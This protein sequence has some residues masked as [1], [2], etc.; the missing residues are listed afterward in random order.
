MTIS[1]MGVTQAEREQIADCKAGLRRHLEK[2][3]NRHGPPITTA[4]LAE[5]TAELSYV[6]AGRGLT[7]V[8]F[9]ELSKQIALHD[10]H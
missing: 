5:L 7:I 4:A 1:G 3:I 6:I 10:E 8:L 2:V 9:A